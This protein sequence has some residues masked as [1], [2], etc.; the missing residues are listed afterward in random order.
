MAFPISLHLLAAV[1]WIGGMFFAL[2]IVRPLCIKLLEAGPAR[3]NLMLSIQGRFLKWIG[4]FVLVLQGTGYWM[5]MKALG[6]FSGLG[7]H[8]NLMLLLGNTMTLLFLYAY[9]VQYPKA[10]ALAKSGKGSETAA[11]ME[12]IRKGTVLNLTL[13]IILIFSGSLGRYMQ[14]QLELPLESAVSVSQAETEH[15]VSIQPAAQ[16][17]A[18]IL[19]QPAPPTPETPETPETQKPTVSQHLLQSRLE[20]TQ[21]WLE[22]E[23]ISN[24]T[25]QVMMLFGQGVEPRINE[26]LSKLDPVTELPSVYVYVAGNGNNRRIGITYGS[27][28]SLERALQEKNHLPAVFQSQQKQIRTVKGIRDEIAKSV[29]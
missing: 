7:W 4:L 11:Q 25:I 16:V 18:P 21:S 19:Q 13:G 20:A 22:G 15:A 24:R 10:V 17:E 27:Y 3:M 8:V 14:P 23:S 12:R 26:M 9:F 2:L 5:I 6:G 1:L 29:K 28:T